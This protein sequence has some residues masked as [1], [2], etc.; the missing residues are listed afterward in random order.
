LPDCFP[1]WQAVYWHF[2]QWKKQNLLSLINIDLNQLDRKREGRDENPSVF[3]IDSQ[4]V[5]LSPMIVEDRGIDANKKVNAG[6][7]MQQEASA[8]SR[9]RGPNLV[10]LRPCSKFTRWSGCVKSECRTD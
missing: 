1:P 2:S 3:C 7:P 8:F 10:R 9:Y 4:S 6:P 5:K